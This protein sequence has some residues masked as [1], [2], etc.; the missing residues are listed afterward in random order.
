MKKAL[1]FLMLLALG[2][3]LVLTNPD[4][5]DF[6]SWTEDRLA[7]GSDNVLTKAGAALAAPALGLAT[8]V[9]DFKVC[10][11]FETNLLGEKQVTLGIYWANSSGSGD[12]GHPPGLSR[13]RCPHRW[14]S[15]AS[16]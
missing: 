5:D 12:G 14:P 11:I 13:F 6:I 15:L 16:F 2:F 7:G 9:R 3:C 4:K 10:S 1:A 8:T